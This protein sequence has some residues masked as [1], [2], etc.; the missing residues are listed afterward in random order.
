[1]LQSLPQTFGLVA[2]SLIAFEAA[3]HYAEHDKRGNRDGGCDPNHLRSPSTCRAGTLMQGL[4]KS[5]LEG[6]LP[7]WREDVNGEFR[8][9]LPSELWLIAVGERDAG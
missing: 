1:M 4:L 6:W 9:P 3:K 7:C 2:P 5:C 8:R